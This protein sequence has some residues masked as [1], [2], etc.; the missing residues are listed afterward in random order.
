M[1]RKYDKIYVNMK[2]GDII[3]Y[4]DIKAKVAGFIDTKK[5]DSFVRTQALIGGVYIEPAD[6]KRVYGHLRYNEIVFDSD[7]KNEEIQKQLHQILGEEYTFNTLEELIKNKANK[8][9]YLELYVNLIYTISISIFTIFS[10]LK[11]VFSTRKKEDYVLW[12][13]GTSRKNIRKMYIREGLKYGV[14][15]SLITLGITLYLILDSYFF[16]KKVFVDTK[17]YINYYRIITISMIPL[18]IF[19]LSYLIIVYRDRE[20]R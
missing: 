7:E 3:T 17:L 5:L 2:P 10:S 6:Y 18:V 11:I 9:I 12:C 4:K 13:V 19:V 8:N 1:T 16:L 20:D 15:S 14:I